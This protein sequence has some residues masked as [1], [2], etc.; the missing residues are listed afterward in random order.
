MKKLFLSSIALLT[1]SISI[2]LF[3]VSCQKEAVA[4]T[5]SIAPVAG[6][7][8]LIKD[9]SASGDLYDT[10]EIWIANTDGSSLQKVNI[11]MPA[12]TVISIHDPKLSPDAKTIYFNGFSVANHATSSPWHVY[13]CNIDGSN[14]KPIID[15][16]SSSFILSDT[17]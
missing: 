12:G 1:L 17:R 3:Q 7:V 9:V 13:S 15:D 10:G 5:Q 11:T 4:Q 8:L 16:S 6:K 2:I 14:L